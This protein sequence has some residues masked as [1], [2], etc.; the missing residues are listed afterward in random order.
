M[1]ITFIANS[2]RPHQREVFHV[3]HYGGKIALLDRMPKWHEVHALDAAVW[4][5]G[6][7]VVPEG[8]RLEIEATAC[9]EIV[10]V[11]VP[12]VTAALLGGTTFGYTLLAGIINMAISYAVGLIINS[13]TA[14]P[15]H[16]QDEPTESSPSYGFGGIKTRRIEGRPRE[17]IYGRIRA[18]GTLI[19]EVID[20]THGVS[21]SATYRA[22]I[23]YGEG[24]IHS[25][26]G[27]SADTLDGQTLKSGEP[28]LEIPPGIEI[29]GNEATNLSSTEAVI[30][31]GSVQQKHAL[32]WNYSEARVASGTPLNAPTTSALNSSS[33]LITIGQTPQADQDAHFNEYG[34]TVDLPDAADFLRVTIRFPRGYF[35]TSGGAPTGRYWRAA[36]RYTR[37]DGSGNPITTGGDFGDGWVRLP[38]GLNE[39]KGT[40]AFSVEY[41]VPLYNPAGY[42]APDNGYSLYTS[43]GSVNEAVKE[44]PNLPGWFIPNSKFPDFTYTTWTRVTSNTG[45]T[46]LGRH[47][48]W[49]HHL[50]GPPPPKDGWHL[51]AEEVTYRT[52]PGQ[53]LNVWVPVLHLY[54]DNTSWDFT[55]IYEGKGEEYYTPSFTFDF[56]GEVAQVAVTYANVG[57]GETRI[58]LYANG[59]MLWEHV[60]ATDYAHVPFD[61]P[62]TGIKDNIGVGNIQGFFDETWY[63]AAERSIEEM[64]SDY[65]EGRGRKGTITGSG[66][67]FTTLDPNL[68]IGGYHFD[69]YGGGG[70]TALSFGTN[71]NNHLILVTNAHTQGD[72]LIPGAELGNEYLSHRYRVEVI[73]NVADSTHADSFDDDVELE[74]VSGVIDSKF[75]YP[76]TPHLSIAVDAQ[77]QLGTNIPP[78]T[79]VVEGRL[80]PHWDGGSITE[81]SFTQSYDRNV[82]ATVLDRLLNKDYGFGSFFKNRQIDVVS[83]QEWYDY[84]NELIDDLKGSPISGDNIDPDGFR[85]MKYD[86]A[87][88]GEPQFDDRGRIEF[89]MED[90]PPSWWVAGAFVGWSGVVTVPS[91]VDH[92]EDADGIGGYEIERV[93]HD[94]TNWTVWLYYDRL[95]EGDPWADGGTLDGGS[96][97]DGTMRGKMRRHTYDAIHDTSQKSW[98]SLQLQASV[99]RG[100][101]VLDGNVARFRINRPRTPVGIVSMAN[102]VRDSFEVSYG[103]PSQRANAYTVEFLDEDA[104]WKRKPAYVEHSSVQNVGDEDDLRHESIFV[105][106]ITRR[107][108]TLSSW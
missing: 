33:A 67:D 82:A 47:W 106:G 94:G 43:N 13:I 98:Q 18:G 14:P 108:G 84:C 10:I 53:T 105:R 44:N 57:N 15:E 28:G 99:G 85:L 87:V 40:S 26:A 39:F 78:I 7:Q 52:S 72:W 91:Y 3:E 1:K 92:N 9:D 48:H 79:S 83:W 20:N 58:R 16:S 102:I 30:R 17:V 63:Y 76:G 60:S 35:A 19:S 81:P 23:A 75:T 86:S 38:M 104:N 70:S 65:N 5:N 61:W 103:G 100:A 101:V 22:Q 27:I 11:R 90:Q 80:V 8:E 4:K 93:F 55:K 66:D 25:I 29:Q 45:Q 32:G 96:P 73:R 36:L 41:Q 6:V 31:L 71:Y 77:E 2:F 88:T 21:G 50:P 54:A 51:Y 64:R 34:V 97:L 68:L 62:G 107:S 69:D 74:A 56:S 37:L 46:G 49:P 42:Q 89:V 24:P 12:G 59:E 95:D